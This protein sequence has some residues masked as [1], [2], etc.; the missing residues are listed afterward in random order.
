MSPARRFVIG[1]THGEP[2]NSHYIG[3]DG[4]RTYYDGL[5]KAIP[6]LH[7]EVQQRDASSDAVV[8]EVIITERHQSA[9]WDLPPTGRRVCFPLCGI[10]VF[11]DDD[12][13]AGEKTYY[14]RATVL[15][16]LGI[17][18]EPDRGLGRIAT[19]IMRT[20][21]GLVGGPLVKTLSV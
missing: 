21:R 13:L 7:I 1:P 5:L 4:V 18:L 10:F 6:N 14:D 19:I 20:E 16:Q 17:F 12:R 15:R 9:W 3:H 2:W 8:V 11:D